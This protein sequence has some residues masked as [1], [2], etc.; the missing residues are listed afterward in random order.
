MVWYMI[1]QH[2]VLIEINGKSCVFVLIVLHSLRT[3]AVLLHILSEIRRF[4]RQPS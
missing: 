1:C 2:Y 4:K 3:H